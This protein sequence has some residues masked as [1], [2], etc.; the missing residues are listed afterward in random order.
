MQ[1]VAH[2]TI[3]H[4]REEF[5]AYQFSQQKLAESGLEVVTNGNVVE[6]QGDGHLEQVVVEFGDGR[7]RELPADLLWSASARRRTWPAPSIGSWA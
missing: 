4:R 6:L 5:S 1:Q 7:R 3:V 2:V